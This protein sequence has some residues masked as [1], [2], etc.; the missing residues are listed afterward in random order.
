MNELTQDRIDRI[1][2]NLLPQEACGGKST[3]PKT[4][5]DRLKY[6]SSPGVSIAVINDFKI[7]WARGFGICWIW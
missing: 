7:E 3:A 2:N 5:S 1:I 6:Y 4:L